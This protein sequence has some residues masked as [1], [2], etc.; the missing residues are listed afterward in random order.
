MSVFI[1]F[2]ICGKQH[3]KVGTFRDAEVETMSYF[4][5]LDCQLM[6]PTKQGEYVYQ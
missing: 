2:S 6:Y 4:N 1:Y 3:D 5:S